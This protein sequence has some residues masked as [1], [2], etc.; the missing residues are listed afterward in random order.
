[1]RSLFSRTRPPSPCLPACPPAPLPYALTV[2]PAGASP[3]G[4]AAR[5]GHHPPTFMHDVFLLGL[6]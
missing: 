3:S 1:M 5:A 4:D 6:G 2:S